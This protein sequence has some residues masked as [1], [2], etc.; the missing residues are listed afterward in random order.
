MQHTMENEFLIVTAD[1]F[2]AEL[3]SVVDKATGAQLL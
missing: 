1:T 3:V 2:G